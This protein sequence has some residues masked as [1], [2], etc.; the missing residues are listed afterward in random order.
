MGLQDHIVTIG[1]EGTYGTRAATLTRGI[2]NQFG[3]NPDPQV[4]Q[5]ESR[6]MRP[7]SVA[8]PNDRLIAIPRNGKIPL[9]VDLMNKSHGLIL[10]GAGSSI[11]SETPDGATT[12]RLYTITPTTAGPTRSSTIHQEIPELE[13]GTTVVDYLGA[14]VTELALSIGPKAFWVLKAMYDYK[15]ENIAAAT[16]VPAYPSAP[17]VYLDTDAEISFDDTVMCQRKYNIAI[18]TGL[19]VS[20]DRVCPDGRRKPVTTG[21]VD[22]TGS[23]EIDYAGTDLWG[24]WKNG[25]ALSHKVLI[26]GPEI[27]DGFNSFFELTVP[28]VRLTGTPPGPAADDLTG[29]TLPFKAVMHAD[30]SPLWTIKYQTSDAVI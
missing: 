22:P 29:Q 19:N 6:G 2:E 4:E 27:E 1:N 5:R 12:A 10:A 23:G 9:Q 28:A 7:G 20:L 18:P 26:T 11:T 16:V 8:V 30:G 21:R 25:I 13:G 14:M 24:K 17:H 3:N 15:A